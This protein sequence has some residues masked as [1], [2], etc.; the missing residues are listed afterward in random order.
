MYLD[1]QISEGSNEIVED[2]WNV[3]ISIG[4][5]IVRVCRNNYVNQPN[6]VF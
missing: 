6:Q 2:I 5:L 3:K 4:A 1:K